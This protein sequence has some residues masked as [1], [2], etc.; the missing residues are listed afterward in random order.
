MNN[1]EKSLATAAS[2]EE[3][4]LRATA[5]AATLVSRMETMFRK[6]NRALVR[7]LGARLGSN[8]GHA[9]DI[10][11]ECFFRLARYN[12]RPEITPAE[13][14]S[15]LYQIARNILIDFY[16]HGKVI[17]AA[18]HVDIEDQE[19]ASPE[20]TQERIVSGQEDIRRLEEILLTL[21]PRCQQVFVLSRFEEMKYEQI[22]THCGISV[23]MVEKHIARAMKIIR[24]KMRV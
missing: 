10:A 24:S 9:E 12:K 22:A 4:E 3:T 6:H 16:R 13:L 8:A 18:D 19:V 21:P 7:F 20:P 11:Q 17:R 15:L 14:H 2:C 5:S 23:S 1:P